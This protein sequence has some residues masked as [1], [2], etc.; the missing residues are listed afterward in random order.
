MSVNSRSL[1]AFQNKV[2]KFALTLPADRIAQFQRRLALDAL[3][4]LI[5][6]TPVDLGRAAGG[7]VI[8]TGQASTFRPGPDEIISP[9]AA[10]AKGRGALISLLPFDIV[11]ITNNVEYIE[12]LERGHSQR[13]A[14]HG[15]LS[16]TITEL[17]GI[18]V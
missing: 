17:S 4:R 8:S 13:Q 2:R 11:F 1:K 10:L 5:E 15:M 6:K 18:F 3:G 14:P 9:E 12:A 7:W 16:S